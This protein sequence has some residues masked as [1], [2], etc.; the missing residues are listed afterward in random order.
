M[1]A[2]AQ[3]ELLLNMRNQV[4]LAGLA[5][6]YHLWD[7]TLRDFIESE[8]KCHFSEANTIAIAWE[9][10]I[11][12]IFDVLKQFGWDCRSEPFFSFIDACRLVVNVY[13]HGKGRSLDELA[14]NYPD[15]LQGPLVDID[16]PGSV[17]GTP[18]YE[19]LIVT[20]SK[21]D[22]IARALRGFWEAFPETLRLQ[23]N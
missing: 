18:D 22:E 2:Q 1:H 20:E 8:V 10:N 17:A 16:E 4:L 11:G 21:F 13:K 5:S 6:L 23:T 19:M 12:K 3:W 14:A 7:K 9:P 15:Y